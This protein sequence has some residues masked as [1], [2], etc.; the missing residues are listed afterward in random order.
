MG[1]C[2]VRVMVC[3][4]LAAAVF[5]G[6]TISSAVPARAD[7]SSVSGAS[8]GS[9]TPSVSTPGDLGDSATAPE[10]LSPDRTGTPSRGNRQSNRS[11]AENGGHEGRFR[12]YGWILRKI[13]RAVAGDIVKV[14]LKQHAA[15]LWTYDVTVL[16]DSG[17]YVQISLNAETGVIISKKKR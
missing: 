17:R 1:K 14:R 11:N 8:V 3:S 2:A 5:Q 7:G 16:D 15:D 4:V 9:Q 10:S 6:A 13:K 12:N